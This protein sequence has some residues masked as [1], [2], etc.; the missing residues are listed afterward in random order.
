MVSA[1]PAVVLMP[2]QSSSALSPS[3]HPA[4]CRVCI[5]AVIAALATRH[6]ETADQLLD[7]K[8]ETS[9]SKNP[10]SCVRIYFDLLGRLPQSCAGELG[11]VRRWLESLIEVVAVR[12][13]QQPF[14]RVPMHL[15][16]D[17]L[18]D[19]CQRVMRDFHDM[20]AADPFSFELRFSYRVG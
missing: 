8:L 9:R 6:R 10:G 4:E 18:E 3:S 5:D 17:T 16:A 2:S 14:A 11:Q 15:E 13:N 20:T 12:E 7:L 19:Y 1:N